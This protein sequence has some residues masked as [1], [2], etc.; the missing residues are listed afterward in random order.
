[1][2]DAEDMTCHKQVM[3]ETQFQLCYCDDGNR[4]LAFAQTETKPKDR[5]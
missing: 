3:S 5:Q 1:M 2:A 4:S